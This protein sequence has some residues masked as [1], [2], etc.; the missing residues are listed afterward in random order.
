MASEQG[1]STSNAWTDPAHNATFDPAE[2]ITHIRHTPSDA[3]IQAGSEHQVDTVD[4]AAASA[5]KK[6]GNA[7]AQ[8]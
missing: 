6:D 3:H 8:K 1:S 2:D 4:W 7:T 5:S